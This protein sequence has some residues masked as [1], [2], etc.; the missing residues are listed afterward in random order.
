MDRKEEDETERGQERPTMEAR[1]VPAAQE[2]T[3]DPGLGKMSP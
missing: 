3:R 1:P 2:Q